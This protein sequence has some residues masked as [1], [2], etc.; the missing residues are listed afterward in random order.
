M[1]DLELDGE[2]LGLNNSIGDVLK[3]GASETRR[4]WS[5]GLLPTRLLATHLKDG[6]GPKEEGGGRGLWQG[7][8]SG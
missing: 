7:R 2:P 6:M 5:G 3:D 8:R 4:D 1:L